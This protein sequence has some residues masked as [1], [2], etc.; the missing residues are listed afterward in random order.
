MYSR[1]TP[2]PPLLPHT[3]LGR[4]SGSG[5]AEA[6]PPVS[7]PRQPGKHHGSSPALQPLPGRRHLETDSK[8]RQTILFPVRALCQATAG[9]RLSATDAAVVTKKIQKM[10]GIPGSSCYYFPSPACSRTRAARP[11]PPGW[12]CG[13]IRREPS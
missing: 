13:R 12:G 11:R 8:C 1:E 6:T 7:F 5:A 3:G 9:G 2:L 4:S 10:K